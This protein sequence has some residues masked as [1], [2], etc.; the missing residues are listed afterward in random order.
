M[1]SMKITIYTIPDCQFCK[2]AKDFLT[3]KGLPFDEKDVLN[4]KDCLLYTSDMFVF[5]IAGV[6]MI[7]D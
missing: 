1:K 4:N 2:Q 6:V 5:V 3:S 7:L